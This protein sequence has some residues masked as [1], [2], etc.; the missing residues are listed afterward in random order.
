MPEHA[1]AGRTTGSARLPTITS[2]VNRAPASGT[3]YTAA[4]P[5]PPPQATRS[6]RCPTERWAQLDRKLAETPPIS[7]GPASRPRDAPMPMTISD[8]SAVPADRRNDRRP[9]PFQIASSISDFCPAVYRRSRYQ[10]TPATIPPMRS[11]A[12]RRRSEA[13]RAPDSRS[14][15][16]YPNARCSTLNSRYISPAP[17]SPAASPVAT[18]TTQKAGVSAVSPSLVT[19]G[20]S[21][22]PRPD[23]SRR[24][25]SGCGMRRR[26][27]GRGRPSAGSPSTRRLSGDHILPPSR[28]RSAHR[29]SHSSQPPY[30]L[31]GRAFAGQSGFFRSG[32]PDLPTIRRA[33]RAGPERWP[34]RVRR[35]RPAIRSGS[36]GRPV[37]T[38]IRPARCRRTA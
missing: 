8:S 36:P 21:V 25:I 2:A 38:G 12:S 11:D 22:A 6:L 29:V 26:S 37:P 13:C 30:R 24:L 23:G 35:G 34:G 9:S 18:R 27:L 19:F 3:L 33:G 15:E 32:R 10:P 16:L 28:A 14:P 5:A 1:R 7:F 4:R 20:C 17:I 31:S